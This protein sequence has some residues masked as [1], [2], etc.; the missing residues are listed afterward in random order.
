MAMSRR[1]RK[2][3]RRGEA[4]GRT[5]L[6]HPARPAPGEATA[7]HG[8]EGRRLRF[9]WHR[10]AVP[11]IRLL[12]QAVRKG[13][14]VAAGRRRPLLEAVWEAA[15]GDYPKQIAAAYV[16]LECERQKLGAAALRLRLAT[17]PAGLGTGNALVA[18]SSPLA[19]GSEGGRGGG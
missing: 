11:D 12:R 10:A 13:W 7:L 15:A 16:L 5:A 6:L 4:T 18:V 3:Q 14:P 1:R 19:L 9:D 2:R 8:K 17:I